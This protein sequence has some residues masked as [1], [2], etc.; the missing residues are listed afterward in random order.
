MDILSINHLLFILI[1]LC[2]YHYLTPKLRGFW[3]LIA[4]FTFYGSISFLLLGTLAFSILFNYWITFSNFQCKVWIAIIV[5][6]IILL[7]FKINESLFILSV[8]VSFFTFQGLS[9]VIDYSKKSKVQLLSFAN[10]MAFFPQLIAEPIETFDD[11]GSQLKDLR[12]IK[13]ENCSEII[14]VRQSF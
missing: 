1:V 5:N 2:V 6:I 8:G 4:S 11:L 13:K 14:N 7:S 12:N 9:F 3:I 10:Y